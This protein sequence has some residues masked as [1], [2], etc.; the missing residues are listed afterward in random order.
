MLRQRRPRDES[1]TGQPEQVGDLQRMPG[2]G[3]E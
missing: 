2:N 1:V 3:A